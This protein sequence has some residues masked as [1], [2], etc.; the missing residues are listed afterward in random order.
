MANLFLGI[1]IGTS[2]VK[3]GIFDEEGHLQSKSMRD[4]QFTNPRDNWLEIEPEKWWDLSVETIQEVIEKGKINPGDIAGISMCGIAHTPV[5]LD[6]E[7]NAVRPTIS[8]LDTRDL[9]QLQ[10]LEQDETSEF[11]LERTGNRIAGCHT[12]PQLLW[13]KEE[14]PDN[15]KRIRKIILSKDY[16][17]YRLTGALSTDLNNASATLLFNNK[18]LC[19]DD[20]ICK[21]F[22]IPKDILPPVVKSSDVIGKVT[23][24]AAQITGLK[25]GTPVVS[26]AG[27]ASI[28]ILGLGI[29]ES[30]QTAVIAGTAGVIMSSWKR[31]IYDNR[32]RCF[33]LVHPAGEMWTL[34]TATN[35]ACTSLDWFQ[36]ILDITGTVNYDIFNKA[37]GESEPGAKGIIFHPFLAGERT[38]HWNPH[39]RSTFFGCQLSHKRGDFIRAVMEGVALS[40]YDCFLIHRDISGITETPINEIRLAGGILN[41]PIWKRILADILGKAIEIPEEKELGILGCAINAAVGVGLYKSY[42]EAIKNMVRL[43]EEITPD[44]ELHNG[45]YAKQFALYRRL[46]ERLAPLYE[47]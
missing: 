38:P 29:V 33:T 39:A 28:A 32:G 2:S 13:V 30:G 40:L 17:G 16:V 12:L 9:A 5:M 27:D 35:T 3:S 6:R 41:S 34:A 18:E 19:W 1:D 10:R 45:I 44:M 47:G 24:E 21:L 22:H 14:E 31:Y 11:I 36:S 43:R 15:F 23:G 42:E 26:G 7:S 46:Y 20:D 8:W 25:E 4:Y 37:A